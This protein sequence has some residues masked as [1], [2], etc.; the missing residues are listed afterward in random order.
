MPVLLSDRNQSVQLTGFY[1]RATL[2]LN[3]LIGVYKEEHLR[4]L[5]LFLIHTCY[6]SIILSCILKD[7]FQKP[8]KTVGSLI[9]AL[10]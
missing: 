9:K 3:G 8:S 10:I 5:I 4:R 2:T 1:M 6:A 7:N